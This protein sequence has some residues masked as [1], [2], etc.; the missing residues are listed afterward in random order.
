MGGNT[1]GIIKYPFRRMAEE[2]PNAV[3]ASINLDEDAPAYL[4]PRS[5]LPSADIGTALQSL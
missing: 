1:P 3:Y 4:G 2:N 5:I